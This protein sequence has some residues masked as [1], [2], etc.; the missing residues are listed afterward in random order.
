MTASANCC[1]SREKPGASRSIACGVNR[2]ASASSTDLRREQQREDAVAE[3]F[4]R[5][6]APPWVRMR[7]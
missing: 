3:Q 7:A 1:G 4:R 2:S 6:R 5:R